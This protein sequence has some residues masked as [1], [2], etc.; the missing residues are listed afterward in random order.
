MGLMKLYEEFLDSKE[1]SQDDIEVRTS[2]PDKKNMF[3][4]NTIKI[5]VYTQNY[6]YR[7][8]FVD[9]LRSIFII[10]PKLC[11]VGDYR[12]GVDVG[13]GMDKTYYEDEIGL[14]G[15]IRQVDAELSR[16]ARSVLN[17]TVDFSEHKVPYRMYVTQ[18]RDFA[19]RIKKIV[20]NRDYKFEFR[21]Q[22]RDWKWQ[23]GNTS[24]FELA[25]LWESYCE[26]YDVPYDGK[27]MTF[28]VSAFQGLSFNNSKYPHMVEKLLAFR[29]FP[30]MFPGYR[31]KVFGFEVYG[32][33][34][35]NNASYAIFVSVQKEDGSV[36]NVE[37]SLQFFSDNFVRK[38]DMNDI[39]YLFSDKQQYDV[40]VYVVCSD[41]TLKMGVI[42][43]D[44]DNYVV[45]DSEIIKQ[46]ND[47]IVGIVAVNSQFVPHN[48]E[49]RNN[50]SFHKGAVITEKD[51]ERIRR[52]FDEIYNKWQ[53]NEY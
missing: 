15:I 29:K 24:T 25:M 7:N 14:E 53:N 18:W 13:F 22:Q 27:M 43:S 45:F 39:V 48:K 51:N 38:F 44:Y 30:N 42:D 35:E 5:S 41:E 28:A 3:F 34:K 10:V 36:M 17:I 33:S 49:Y 52:A 9:L 2:E 46:K 26:M 37:D 8:S 20:L 47:A 11:F 19:K 31:I 21:I 12:L 16:V 6:Y 50:D 1:V 32:N 23:I 40:I 4:D